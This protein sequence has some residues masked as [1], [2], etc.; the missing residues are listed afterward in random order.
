MKQTLSAA[1]RAEAKPEQLGK[2]EFEEKGVE[3][4]TGL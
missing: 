2:S 4:N 3:M 1:Q